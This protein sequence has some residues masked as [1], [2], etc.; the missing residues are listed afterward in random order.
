MA[1]TVSTQ[2]R[3]ATNR[4]ACP[5]VS[6]A[7]FHRMTLMVKLLLGLFVVLFLLPLG[8][9]ALLHQRSSVGADWWGADRSSIG[10]LPPA[11]EHP[12]AVV[13]VF[14][15]PTV[16][17]RGAFAVHCWIVLKRE[18]ETTYTRY[19]YTAW[20]E[21]I[22]VNGFAPDGRWFG[23]AP[24]VVF[25]ADGAAATAMI[26]RMR[27]AIDSYAWRNH[28]DYR[29]W[30]GPNSNTFVAA[31]LEAV[32]EAEAVLPPTAIGKD[33]PW[34]GR[35]LRPVASGSG[36][37]WTLA[38]YAGLTLGWREGI[39]VNI[40]GAVA[41]LDLRYPAIKLPGLGRLGLPATGQP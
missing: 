22:R 27:A 3:L 24:A 20:G 15:A 26:P 23:R 37:R 11:T 40:L 16:R 35:W 10:L 33:Y 32:P 14:A 13:R 38:G 12:G 21:P 36:I 6:G 31:V 5:F 28:G 17:W 1:R 4:R 7:N 19:D 39:E 34:D 18:G 8:I 25:A 41:G 9:A 30:P 2:S 29:A